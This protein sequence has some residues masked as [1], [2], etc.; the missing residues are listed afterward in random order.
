MLAK[1]TGIT[2]LF[3]K[4]VFRASVANSTP[5]RKV[6]GMVLLLTVV[7]TIVVF[8]LPQ[9]AAFSSPAKV[10]TSMLF[11]VMCRQTPGK[12]PWHSPGAMRSSL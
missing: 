6:Q 11:V 3:P 1:K 4:F 5:K 12:N 2:L 8:V 9:L 10:T 7:L